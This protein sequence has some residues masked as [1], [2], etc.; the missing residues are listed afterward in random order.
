M[1]LMDL[2]PDPERSVTS[3]RR[4]VFGIITA[5]L[6][7]FSVCALA[8]TVYSLS[9]CPAQLTLKD[10]RTVITVSDLEKHPELLTAMG[11]TKDEA[12]ADWQARGVVLQAWSE[13]RTKYTCIEITVVKDSESEQYVD[14]VHLEDKATWSAYVASCKNSEALAS[15]GYTIQ[16]LGT[17]AKELQKPEGVHFLLLKYKRSLNGSEYRGYMAK[18]V[19]RG[20]SVCVDLKCFNQIPPESVTNEITNI[21]KTFR[22]D[23]SIAA[24]AAASAEASAGSQDIP[25]TETG[26]TGSDEGSKISISAAPPV[27][28]NTN[29]FTV[30][31]TTV[32]G[33][34]V[35]GVLMRIGTDEV[36]NFHASAHEKKGTFKMKV[37]IPEAEENV[38][39]FALNVYTADDQFVAEKVFPY[40]TY[41]KTLIP[42][43]LDSAV[44]ESFASDELVITGTTVKNVDI[45]CLVTI[46]NSPYNWNKTVRT[47]GTGR[48]TFKIPLSDEGEYNIVLVFAKKGLD[49][50]RETYT[51]SHI[52]TDE[53]RR[54]QIRKSAKTAGYSVISSGIGQF[55]GQTLR[56]NNLYIT[57]IEQVG[58]QW[59]IIAAGQQ[60]S[61]ERF[62]QILY[63]VYEQEPGFSVG[64]RH[65]LYGK[66]T[67]LYNRESEE[68]VESYPQFDLLLWD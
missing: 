67:G 8:D 1:R 50:H 14:L 20:Y 39:L 15:Q 63:F 65:T 9:P 58:D 12:V 42:V 26:D 32:P 66:C 40:I 57:N 10:K 11:M 38:W 61:E 46:T 56:F 53:A 30:E 33:T 51:V 29:V 36:L 52:L 22:T 27:E 16:K 49:T 23:E 45:Q 3:L 19:Y 48:F 55:I 64:E 62:N 5:L 43:S 18:T 60:I 34:E 41:K 54:V 35:I 13:L 24:A 47:N 59:I 37:T 44:P 2:L 4:L 6:L 68:A 28:T 17:S 7:V 31:G 21:M 25:G